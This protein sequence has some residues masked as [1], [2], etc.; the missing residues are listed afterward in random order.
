MSHLHSVHLLKSYRERTGLSLQ[1]M[2]TMIGMDT[3]NLSKV[4]YG[5]LEPSITIILAYHLILKIPVERIFKYHCK[6]VIKNSLRNSLALKENLMEALNKP[7]ISK[8]IVQ[9]DTIIDRLVLLDSK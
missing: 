3:G 7:N 6:E 8:R 5:K 4:E 1:D 2:A 9:I